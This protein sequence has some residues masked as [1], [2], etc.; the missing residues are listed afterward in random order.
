VHLLLFDIDGTLFRGEGVGSVALKRAFEDVFG[1][2]AVENGALKGI[3][4]NGRSDPAIIADMAAALGIEAEAFTDATGRFRESYLA[5]LTERVAE[6][7]RKR[8]LPGAA[9]LIPR[10]HEDPRVAL[11]LLTGN[12]EAGARIKLGAFDFNR[13]FPFG[14][15]G[16]DG[17]DR[18]VLARCARERGEEHHRR[19]FEPVSVLVV[20]DTVHDVAAAR[21]NGFTAVGVETGGVASDAMLAAGAAAVFPGLDGDFPG[22]LEARMNGL[23]HVT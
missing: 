18:T 1:V 14:G 8:L 20:G 12:I 6:S 2:A 13:F 15:F 23:Q 21:A 7:T 10:L 11:G 5:H 19:R 9:E 22:W 17:V 16:D 4:F 3:P